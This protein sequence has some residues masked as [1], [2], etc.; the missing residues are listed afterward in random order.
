[1]KQIGFSICLIVLLNGCYNNAHLRTQKVLKNDEKVYSGSTTIN[2]SDE[3][4][5]D[6]QWPGVIGFRG[7]GSMLIGKPWGEVGLFGGLGIFDGGVGYLFGLDYH[8]YRWTKNGTG[9]KIGGQTEIN[10]IP[11]TYESQPDGYALQFRPS[12]ST[13]TSSQKKLYG[14]LHG[15]YSIGRLT[16]I[17][18]DWN[19]VEVQYS[20]TTYGFGAMVGAEFP[21][22]KTSIQF[23][24]DAS[25]IK[26]KSHVDETFDNDYM[27]RDFSTF[28]VSG[29]AGLNFYKPEKNKATTFGPY[30]KP[31]TQL[32]QV[33]KKQI[34]FD[35]ITGK[36]IIEDFGKQD[37]DPLTGKPIQKPQKESKQ[38]TTFLG[39]TVSDI[40]LDGGRIYKSVK[41]Q[42]VTQDQ[43]T[44]TLSKGVLI[45]QGKTI[46]KNST[47]VIDLEKIHSMTVYTNQ[48][49]VSGGVLGC[50]GGCAVGFITPILLGAITGIDELGV[51]LLVTWPAGAIYGWNE[52]RKTK[53]PIKLPL[54]GLSTTERHTKIIESVKALNK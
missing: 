29:S 7:E 51:I 20:Q 13:I 42:S 53:S 46:N 18:W 41:L 44:F 28:I 19:E 24:I 45:E 22:S 47:K 1:M 6:L 25:L 3:I 43:L 15:L 4:Y 21:F 11:F 34:R 31:I 54:K 39:G 12:I 35:P 26:G 49:N 5:G 33:E 10:I 52:G 50:I 2:I 9:L 14:G 17:V 27:A 32:K 40:T 38:P 37:F 48:R 36:E 16:A 8:R 30:P 23:E